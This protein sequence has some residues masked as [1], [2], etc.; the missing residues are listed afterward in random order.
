[1]PHSRCPALLHVLLQANKSMELEMAEQQCER[2]RKE[3]QALMARLQA[4][5]GALAAC[6]SPLAG[7]GGLAARMAQVGGG[8]GQQMDAVRVCMAI[9]MLGH[10]YP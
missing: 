3:N 10:S 4:A 2:L 6:G 5:L 9:C 8:G 1:M 7:P